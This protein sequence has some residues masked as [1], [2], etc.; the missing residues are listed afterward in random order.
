MLTFLNTEP[1]SKFTKTVANGTTTIHE[2]AGSE[3]KPSNRKGMGTVQRRQSK[4][5]MP[6]K[7]LIESARFAPM[8]LSPRANANSNPGEGKKVHLVHESIL[9]AIEAEMARIYKDSPRSSDDSDHDAAQRDGRPKCNNT[10]GMYHYSNEKMELVQQHGLHSASFD[11]VKNGESSQV[12]LFAVDSDL[13]MENSSGVAVSIGSVGHEWGLCKPCAFF[14]KRGCN[15]GASCFFCH[16]CNAGE[17]KRR[18]KNLREHWQGIVS[19][20]FQVM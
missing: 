13:P 14:P 7:H 3:S 15:L 8:K 6:G 20:R 18:K 10:S 4:K 1:R 2:A 17:R 19:K 12:G 11:L 16:L 5:Y 9:S